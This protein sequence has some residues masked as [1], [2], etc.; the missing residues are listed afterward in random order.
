MN[1]RNLQ[2]IFKPNYWYMHYT[3]NKEVDKI[4]NE[5]LDNHELTDLCSSGYTVRIGK[6]IIW[7]TNIP[8]ASVRL[9]G[10]Q[11]ENYRP[12][13]LT[14]KRFLKKYYELKK[15]IDKNI[16]LQVRNELL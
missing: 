8:Y 16:V 2:F 10:T 3:Y 1:F 5:L 12:S 13:R 15:A 4:I 11:L 9:Y 7:T 14:I 6:A